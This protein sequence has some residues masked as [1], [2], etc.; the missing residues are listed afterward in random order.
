MSKKYFK[1]IARKT[2]VP[3]T[4]KIRPLRNLITYIAEN[5]NDKF[6]DY[7]YLKTK[8]IENGKSSKWDENLRHSIVRRFEKIDDT[9]P[10]SS[11]KAD[12]LFIA[13][14]LLS[15]NAEGDVV[16]CGCYAGGSTAKLSIISKIV[17]RRLFV[18]DSFEGLPESDEYNLKDYHFRR[19]NKWV[20]DWTSGR[21]SASLEQVNS[22]IEKYGE[23]SVCTFHKGWFCDTLNSKNLPQKISLVDTDVATSSASRECLESIWPKMPEGGVFFTHSA[24]YLKVLLTLC[25]RYLWENVFKTFPPI[26]FGAGGGMCDSSPHLGFLIKGN[27]ITPEY[28]KGLTIDK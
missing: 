27:T 21:Y 10:M 11:K 16:E 5:V 12:G 1:T 3:V 15:I 9:I 28:I 20:T 2:I 24:P 25:D 4:K 26:F 23:I 7:D 19:S 6:D 18:F 22:N 14:T 17:G 13:E 8:F